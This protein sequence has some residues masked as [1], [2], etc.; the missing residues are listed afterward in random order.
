MSASGCVGFRIEL[1][2]F[3]KPYLYSHSDR[4]TGRASRGQS[5]MQCQCILREKVV[6]ACQ[7]GLRGWAG[8]VIALLTGTHIVV[9]SS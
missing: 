2:E 6:E 1:L 4:I 8:I 7:Q 3:H 5:D 9:M